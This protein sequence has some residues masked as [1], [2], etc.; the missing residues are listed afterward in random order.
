MKKLYRILIWAVGIILALLLVAVVLVQL[1]FPEEKARQL[2]IERGSAALGRDIDIESVAVSFWGG[3]GVELQNVTIAN[4]PGFGDEPMARAAVIDV[5]LSLLPL[6][7]GEV[8]IDR[9]IVDKL[10]AEMIKRPNGENNYTFAAAEEKVPSRMKGKVKPEAQAAAAT[11][12]FDRLEIN[13]GHVRYQNDSSRLLLDMKNLSLATS[14]SIPTEAVYHSQ[15]RALVET[16][17]VVNEKD[18]LPPLTVATRHQ[19]EFDL[20]S[21]RLTLQQSELTVN[22]L[23]FTAHGSA[24]LG[25]NAIL[26]RFNV[27]SNQIGAQDLLD[28][29]PPERLRSAGEFTAS[30]E[31]SLD[32]DITYD[33]TTIDTL[34]YAGS[35]E[36]SDATLSR[37]DI[38]GDLEIGSALIDFETNTLRLSLREATF[39]GQPLRG[40]VSVDNFD[41]PHVNG[42]LAGKLDLAFVQPFLSGRAG[43]QLSG[44]LDFELQF[45]GQL[46]N[47]E[48]L[49]LS[50]QATIQNG[51]YVSTMFPEPIDTLE[52]DLF[53]DNGTTRIN[54]LQAISKRARFEATGRIQNMIPYLLLDSAAAADL[55]PEI[56]VNTSGE[57]DLSLA[58]QYLAGQSNP[59]LTGDAAW[60]MTISGVVTD[61]S[62]FE[63]RGTIVVRQ[64][65][66]TDDLLPEPIERFDAD[67]VVTRDTVTINQLDVV[68]PSSDLSLTGKL[69]KPF[70]N[71]LPFE[72]I[73]YN[74]YRKPSLDFELTSN[75]LNTDKLFPEAVPGAETEPPTDTT[76]PDQPTTTTP[77]QP[78]VSPV[79]LPDINGRGNIT[80][81]TLIYSEID[82]TNI[83]A[84]VRIQ[85]RKIEVYEANASVYDG[86]V[87]G[88]T[89]IDLTDPTVPVYTGR[90]Q[91]AQI[92]AEGFFRQFTPLSDQ[93]TGK[94]NFN[95]TYE[96]TGTEKAELKRSLKLDADLSMRDGQFEASN[97]TYKIING[98]AREVG[99]S[100]D[101]TQNFKDLD[102]DIK[103]E[104]GKVKADRLKT[105]L[106]NMG[107]LELDGYY[108]FDG[109][110]D[111]TGSILLSQSWSEK[112]LKNDI[113]GGLAD[114]LSGGSTE[115]LKLPLFISGSI[116]NPSV[117]IDLKSVGKDAAGGMLNNLKDLL[118]KK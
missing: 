13:E 118:Q 18:T 95:G 75:R 21:N 74:R 40:Q 59:E 5:K 61:L 53:F 30:G 76:T 38:P 17:L 22:G 115:R 92:Q 64:A 48:K 81:D 26:A 116:D 35:L 65:T 33:E 69:I 89:T 82:F 36:L 83:T 62:S 14:L 58:N 34:Q 80:V 84:R 102:T 8:N 77:S 68:F 4:A 45:A 7:T 88:G 46:A 79:I 41:D 85:D 37:E 98:I 73:E 49:D 29:L 47:Y 43:S 87:T 63:P 107:D 103:V 96:T 91:A 70:P 93:V 31:L 1:F 99:E 106:G 2:A 100:I 6:L 25:G 86:T 20:G 110:V 94:M 56:D 114:I 32:A 28:L 24:E 90:F 78:V 108:G 111:Y 9:L 50:G 19:A 52:L 16:L 104:D 15:G 67:L 105:S 112:I 72:G 11:V 39:D 23:T 55:S 71:L 101:R 44:Q 113:I 51:R 27:Q 109:S 97:R 42:D 3:F 10:R 117:G 57:A 66:Y 54:S 60:D 12:S